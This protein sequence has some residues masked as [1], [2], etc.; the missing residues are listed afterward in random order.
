MLVEALLRRLAEESDGYT[1]IELMVSMAIGLVIALAAFGLIEVTTRA[2]GRVTDQVGANQIGRQSAAYVESE[3]QA[4]C[5]QAGGQ[6][7]DGSYWGPIQTN[8]TS[9]SSSSTKLVSDGSD[10]VFWTVSDATATAGVTY[11]STG[12]SYA[13]HYIQFTS[14]TLIDTTWPVTSGTSPTGTSPFVYGS[15]TTRTLG[16]INGTGVVSQ[17][18]TTPVFQYYGYDSSY[19]LSAT[20]MTLPLTTSTTPGIASVAISYQV[21]G[22]K[23][24]NTAKQNSSQAAPYIVN[25]N[26]SLRL[27]AVQSP[28]ASNV[29]YPCQ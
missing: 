7:S 4:S 3:L 9:P 10:I 15:P 20:P 17:V 29:P 27:T 5:I 2:T 23:G 8:I 14:G 18:G 26:V 6:Q 12:T 21:E 25:D 13:L 16:K 11:A 19:N 22:N 28:S 24:D 1:L